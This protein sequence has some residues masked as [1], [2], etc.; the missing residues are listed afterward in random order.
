MK[1]EDSEPNGSGHSAQFNLF[2]IAMLIEVTLF[3]RVRKIAKRRLLASSCL[4][5]RM[6]QLGSYV[7]DFCEI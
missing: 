2:V 7:T 3:R 4:T 6:E 5:V 1:K